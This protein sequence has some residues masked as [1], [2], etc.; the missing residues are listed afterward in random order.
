MKEVAVFLRKV[1]DVSDPLLP[2]HELA[3]NQIG[4]P[5]AV[6]SPENVTGMVQVLECRA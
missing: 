2:D 5:N 3:W 4:R 6:G 1:A